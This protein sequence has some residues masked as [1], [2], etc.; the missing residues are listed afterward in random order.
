MSRTTGNDSA[1]A[2]PV[3]GIAPRVNVIMTTYNHRDFIQ[4]AVESV[5]SQRA[6]FS[7]DL[8]ILDDVSTDG[9]GQ[10]I[11]E[12]AARHAGIVRV[13]RPPV[14]LNSNAELRR[15][16]QLTAGEFVAILDG[17]DYWT[18]P[19]KLR[20]QVAF[21]DENP[22]LSMCFHDCTVVDRNGDVI[23]DSAFKYGKPA[24]RTGYRNIARANCVP[25][26]SPMIRRKAISPLPAW[27]DPYEWGDWAIF[28]IAAVY[29]PI[30]FMP[31]RMAAY[32]RH[33]GGYWTGMS[34]EL[35]FR[36][37]FQFLRDFEARSSKMRPRYAAQGMGAAWSANFFDAFE[38]RDF[39]SVRGLLIA[40]F[41]VARGRQRLALISYS[42]IGFLRALKSRLT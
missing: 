33:G 17:D 25:G 8:T 42:I 15:A 41:T 31:E 16:I 7:F 6:E 24:V 37:T 12:L 32:R 35:R 10:I 22:G 19:H 1:A 40:L 27:L 13:L 30:G 14:N 20:K 9:T 34:H 11:E 29:G 38:E 23:R 3:E 5:L 4:Q 2:E 39:A 28:L 26:P 36:T 21:L 18:D